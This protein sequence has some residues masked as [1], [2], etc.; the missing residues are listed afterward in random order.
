MSK[1]IKSKWSKEELT[2]CKLVAALAVAFLVQPL[3]SLS[4]PN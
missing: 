2:S 1:S 3:S 4:R